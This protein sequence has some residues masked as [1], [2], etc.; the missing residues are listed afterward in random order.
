VTSARSFGRAGGTR[1]LAGRGLTLSGA[2]L[3]AALPAKA[4]SACVSSTLVSSTVNAAASGAAGTLAAGAVSIKAAALA[5]GIVKSMFLT[6]LKIGTALL[7]AVTFLV[8]G[9]GMLTYHTLAAEPA[10]PSKQPPNRASALSDAPDK[11]DSW[12]KPVNGLQ[13]RL[14]FSR[15]ET[16]RSGAITLPKATLP[17]SSE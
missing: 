2:A 5:E 3:A 14:R 13:A 6:K 10:E 16:L 11:P 17:T 9:A 15:K 7:L 8:G 12:S 4:A 1:R